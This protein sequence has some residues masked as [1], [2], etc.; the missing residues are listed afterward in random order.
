MLNNDTIEDN[1][2]LL[3]P[4]KLDETHLKI[5]NLPKWVMAILMRNEE[6]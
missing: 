5:L 3:L 2:V 1:G 6:W 4:T